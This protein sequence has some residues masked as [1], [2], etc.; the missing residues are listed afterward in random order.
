MSTDNLQEYGRRSDAAAA[1]LR[2][3]GFTQIDE[4]REAINTHVNGL[5]TR[6]KHLAGSNLADQWEEVDAIECSEG[7]TAAMAFARRAGINDEALLKVIRNFGLHHAALVLKLELDS[8]TDQMC[9]EDSPYEGGGA[10]EGDPFED[11]DD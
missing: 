4:L 11:E 10:G 1:E 9:T 5:I 8:L 3:A 7:I 6:I 2:E